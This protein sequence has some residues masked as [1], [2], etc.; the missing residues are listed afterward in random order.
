MGY[1]VTFTCDIIAAW[2]LYIL[3]K[4]VNIYLS[5]L[6]ALF[7][8]VFA[9]IAIVSLIN[10]VDAFRLVTNPDYSII[11]KPCQVQ[12]Q[13]M[14]YVNSFRYGFHFVLVFFGFYLG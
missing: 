12:A 8:L 2:A 10:L 1:L 14:L 7:R 3:L 13:T 5:A 6:T 11:F 9:V 4:P